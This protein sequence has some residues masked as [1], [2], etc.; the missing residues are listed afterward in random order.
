[1]KLILI[2]ISI[3]ILVNCSKPKTVLICGDHVCVNKAEAEQYFQDN[4]S[5]E[6]RVV[7]KKFKNETDLVEL[8]LKENKDGVKKISILSKKN[9]KKN[10]KILSNKE[11]T[12][13]K[14]NI[15]DKSKRKKLTKKQ[16]KK[17]QKTNIGKI[18]KHHVEKKTLE[19]EINKE[20]KDVV[21][22]CLL[23][24]KCSIDEISKYLL[25][26]GEKKKFPDITRTQ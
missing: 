20:H 18:K 7:E 13:I 16:I 24:E 17:N 11:I 5:I 1:M 14:K 15:N 6:V 8:N 10:L 21:D 3:I 9:T 25:K 26:K 4:L 19:N 22:V 2:F 12:K 23:L